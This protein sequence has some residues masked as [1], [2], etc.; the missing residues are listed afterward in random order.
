MLFRKF[1]SSHGCC[2]GIE[3]A[4]STARANDEGEGEGVPAF[5]GIGWVLRTGFERCPVFSVI[6][7]D[8]GAVGAYGD[9]KFLLG[10]VG[11]GGA[12]AVGWSLCR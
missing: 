2:F 3:F 5:V 6:A 4:D 7:G 10:V 9:P 8:V 12:E 1:E 11:Y